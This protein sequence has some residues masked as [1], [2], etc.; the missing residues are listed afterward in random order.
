MKTMKTK[1][2]F[3]DITGIHAFFSVFPEN[4]ILNAGGDGNADD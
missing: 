1:Y 4:F 3:Y 2:I